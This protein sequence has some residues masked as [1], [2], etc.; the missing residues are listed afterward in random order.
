MN[1]QQLDQLIRTS[2]A[3]RADRQAARQPSIRAAAHRLSARLEPA[4]A[5]LRPRV[6]V[7]PAATGLAQ[8][9]LT[10][11]LLLALLAAAVVVGSSL[12]DQRRPGTACPDD[13]PLVDQLPPVV[14]AYGLA[15]NETDATAR[16]SLIE[17]A[18]AEDATYRHYLI[19]DVVVGRDGYSGAIADFQTAFPGHY[20]QVRAW[21]P[22]DRHHDRVQLR[23]RQCNADGNV[24]LEGS[25]YLRLGPD[26]LIAEA[27]NF[28]DHP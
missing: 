17:E 2:L 22:T 15:W 18:L 21:A 19:D 6:V 23:W 26:G 1:D 4:E 14:A 9:L 27:V 13:D 20:F 16:M 5:R 8:M 24:E 7:A 3:W 11:L 28:D 25:D 12:L 10:L